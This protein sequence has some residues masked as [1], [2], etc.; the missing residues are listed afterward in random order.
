MF[1]ISVTCCQI[2]STGVHS[3]VLL[4]S[5]FKNCLQSWDVLLDRGRQEEGMPVILFF[6]SLLL[7]LFLMG[8]SD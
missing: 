3:F 2:S 7:T 1:L 6:L 5:A 8:L 4:V